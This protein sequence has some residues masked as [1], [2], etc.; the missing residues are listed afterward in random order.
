MEF[1]PS[2]SNPA[3]SRLQVPW[4]GPQDKTY[5]AAGLDSWLFYPHYEGYNIQHI[6]EGDFHGNSWE[7]AAGF[8]QRWAYWGMIQEI[9]TIGG[10]EGYSVSNGGA[11]QLRNFSGSLI[12]VRSCPKLPRTRIRLALNSPTKSLPRSIPKHSATI[13]PDSSIG[14]V[15]ATKS[16]ESK[17]ESAEEV[18]GRCL[19]LGVSINQIQESLHVCWP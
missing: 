4:F 9:L 16:D 12:C 15:S 8:V 11:D 17:G 3:F 18:A 10:L 19:G 13:Q 2:V 5:K 1:V 7:D 14:V 6:A